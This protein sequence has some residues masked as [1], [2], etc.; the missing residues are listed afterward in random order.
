MLGII[1]T[2]WVW[3]EYRRADGT[4]KNVRYAP[5]ADPKNLEVLIQTEIVLHNGSTSSKKAIRIPE[6]MFPRSAFLAQSKFLSSF[7]RYC[8]LC[9]FFLLLTGCWDLYIIGKLAVPNN[10]KVCL[11]KVWFFGKS[12]T[13]LLFLYATKNHAI[14]VLF[15]FG[16]R[17]FWE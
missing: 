14:L 5:I 12:Y 9:Y 13:I 3:G 17:D 16:T 4:A 7:S 8:L 6:Y 15:D 1:F 11:W 2:A 10:Y